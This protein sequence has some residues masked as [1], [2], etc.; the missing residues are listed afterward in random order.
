M[1]AGSLTKDHDQ[2]AV[3]PLR[4]NDVVAAV[5]AAPKI[6][7][8]Q[9]ARKWTPQSACQ[10]GPLSSGLSW[11]CIRGTRAR[12][13]VMRDGAARV[14]GSCAPTGERPRFAAAVSAAGRILDALRGGAVWFSLSERVADCRDAKDNK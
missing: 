8:C 10:T 11:R 1:L 5:Q 4:L 3:K 2:V 9:S 13:A 7:E 14:G 12:R 6:S